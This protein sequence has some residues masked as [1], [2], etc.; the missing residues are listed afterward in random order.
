MSFCAAATCLLNKDLGIMQLMN[1]AP[2]MVTE[3]FRV[4]GLRIR[5]LGSAFVLFNQAT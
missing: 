5:V 1:F 2:Q 3:G 4:L